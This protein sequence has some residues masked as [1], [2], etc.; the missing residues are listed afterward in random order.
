MTGYHEL[1][2][3]I[4][5]FDD[6][7]IYR[8]FAALNSK[9]LLF[10]QAELLHLDLQLQAITEIDSR[11]AEKKKFSTYRKA[12]NDALC[13]GGK[14]PQKQKL[15]KLNENLTNTVC[16]EFFIENVGSSSPCADAALLQTAKVN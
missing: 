14:D 16:S 3:L 4:R 6:L 1:A 2:T 12:L 15:P 9:R 13:E 7:A 5:K 11:D 8:R 10:I